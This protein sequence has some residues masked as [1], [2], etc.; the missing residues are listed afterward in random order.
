MSN[1]VSVLPAGVANATGVP[2]AAK[3]PGVTSAPRLQPIAARIVMLQSG[4]RAPMGVKVK[5]PD[6]DTIEKVALEI[7]TYLK[8][9]PNVEASAVIADR[10]VDLAT[11]RDVSPAQIAL[12]WLLAQKKP[13]SRPVPKHAPCEV[14]KVRLRPAYS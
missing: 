1:P 3:V 8:Q 13:R 9:V 10:V 12:A 11:K 5:G 2:A 6:L 7:E 14:E 4:M